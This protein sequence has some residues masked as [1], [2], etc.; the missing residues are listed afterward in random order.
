MLSACLGRQFQPAAA[1][2]VVCFSSPA[3]THYISVLQSMIL[4]GVWPHMTLISSIDLMKSL[5]MLPGSQT[6]HSPN[7]YYQSKQRSTHTHTHMQTAATPFAQLAEE[8]G[9]GKKAERMMWWNGHC[10]VTWAK[11]RVGEKEGSNERER[12]REQENNDI[13]KN[14]L[15]TCSSSF[16]PA[17]I[18]D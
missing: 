10:V 6:L 9:E 3:P 8:G 16:M 2:A 14:G 18:K 15:L 11:W 4:F 1:A 7:P 12:E 13:R 17:Q 5:Q